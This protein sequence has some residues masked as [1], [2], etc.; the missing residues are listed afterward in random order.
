VWIESSYKR[1]PIGQKKII[2]KLVD[3]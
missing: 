1:F 2:Q 3:F